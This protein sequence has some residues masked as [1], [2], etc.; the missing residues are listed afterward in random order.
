MAENVDPRAPY[1]ADFARLDEARRSE[2]PWL[3]TR[4]EA[5]IARFAELGFPNVK[6]EE[7]KYTNVAPIARTRFVP[8]PVSPRGVAR[9]WLDAATFGA[10]GSIHLVFVDGRFASE[11]STV[12]PASDGFQVGS[13]GAFFKFDGKLEPSLGRLTSVEDNPFTALNTAFSQDG[14]YVDIPKGRVVEQPIHLTFLSSPGEAA[15][16]AHPRN[17]VLLGDGSRA[18]IVETYLGQSDGVYFTNSVTEVSVGDHAALD[19]VKVQREAERAFHVGTMEVHPSRHASVSCTTVS[20]GGALVRSDVNTAFH[21]EGADLALNGLFVLGGRQ[22]FDTHTR[23]DHLVPA[24]TSREFYKGI[25]GG[26]SRGVFNG[27]IFVRRGA[28][29]TVAR[30]TNK[31]LLLSRDAHVDS[32]PG[33]EILADDVK[34][35]HGSTIGQLDEN[36]VFYLRSRGM[37]DDTAKSLL[38][39]AFG[40]EIVGLIKVPAVR[41]G[42][43]EFI[44]SRLPNS[45]AVREAL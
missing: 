33:L 38:T 1:L 5:A 6:H 42:L 29:K 4:R 11:L 25:L 31:N 13:L 17:L 36:A 16:V 40:A 34:C 37:D 35:N 9:A 19:Y 10:T 44:L 15:W 12:P 39:Y 27:Q 28:Q 3:R 41:K 32:T 7:W 30:Q 2:P 14:A 43:S 8:A 45:D 20:L 22:H 26:G 23:I 21:G 24:C 18:T